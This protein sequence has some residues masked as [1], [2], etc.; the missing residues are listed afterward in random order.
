MQ[1]YCPFLEA[2]PVWGENLRTRKNCQMGFTAKISGVS[3]MTQV[4]I[5]TAGHYSIF[6]NGK[7]VHYGPARAA[8]GYYRVDMTDL[9]LEPGEN[10]VAIH[11]INHGIASFGLM[12]QP[13]FLQAEIV[14]RD[15]VLAATGSAENGF[16]AYVLSERVQKIQRY[17]YQRPFAEGYR[18][19]PDY[20]DWMVGKECQNANACGTVVQENKKLLPRGLQQAAFPVTPMEKHTSWG[21]FS[22]QPP[23]ELFKDRSLLYAQPE[24]ADSYLEGYREDQLAWHLSDEI[25]AFQTTK[26]TPANCPVPPE[27]PV[28]PGEF[29]I[30]RLQGERTGFIV[31]DI[32]CK[33]AG[34]L[35]IL[36][37]EILDAQSDV[38]ATRMRCCNA[39]RL[40]C[41]AGSYHF[42][43]QE[44]YS[45]KYCKVLSVSGSFSVSGG[46][47]IELICPER[48]TWDYHSENE[49][50]EAV[51]QAARQTFLQNSADIFMDCP[52]RERAGWLCDSFFLGRS[53]YAFTGK[54]SVERN[55]LENYALPEKFENIPAGMVPMCY[56]SDQPPSGYIPNWAMWLLIELA[57]YCERTGQRDMAQM[58]TKRT[59]EL[60]NWFAQYENAHGLLEKLPGWIFVEWSKSNEF[61]QDINY[62][63]NMLYGYMLQKVGTLYNREDWHTKGTAILETVR[64]KSFDGDFFVDNAVYNE[65]NVA[66]N[67]GNRTETC[68]YYAFFTGTATPQT[69]PT[70]WRRL[71]EEFGVKRME[72]GLYPE[73][74]PSNAFIGNYLRMMLL[75][76]HGYYGQMLEEAVDYFYY[77]AQKTGTLWEFSADSASCNHGFASYIAPLIRISEKA[78]LEKN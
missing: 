77:M 70:L 51:L 15:E 30:L 72:R 63:T 31:M 78:I 5:A 44:S 1:E 53:E 21:T 7:F 25:Q 65:E 55:F 34:T 71:T 11:A 6:I 74:H 12:S 33:K 62:P 28:N 2:K 16:S 35:Y 24:P 61:V 42:Q 58:F 75:V 41:E 22:I 46:H 39:I 69:H 26:L 19:Q 20:R 49:K 10:W 52:S 64:E 68:Q 17:S 14:G 40:D 23:K 3:G 47:L 60:L 48:I 38:S 56:P 36:F 8:K 27:L 57:E 59:T 18:L 9:S 43:S 66:V 54:N 76:E 13:A 45:L 50:I 67:T 4:R 37:D 32:V 73:I 29:Q